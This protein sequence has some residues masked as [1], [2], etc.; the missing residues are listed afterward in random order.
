VSTAGPNQTAS[1]ST[2]IESSTAGSAA[3]SMARGHVDS[4]DNTRSR[5]GAFLK[6]LR[7][8]H[9]W[10]GLWGALL[11]LLFGITGFFLNHRA[12]PLRVPTGEPQVEMVQLKVP[13]QGFADPRALDAWVRHELGIAGRSG[14]VMREP[15]RRVAWGDRSVMQP[16]HWQLAIT[17]PTAGAQVEYWVGNDFVTVKRSSNT[18]LATL[19]NLHK[20]VGLGVPWVLLVDTLAGSLILLSITGVLLWTGMNK[21]RTTG[22]VIIGVAIVAAI[23][24]GLG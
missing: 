17:T 8:I 24:C 2:G 9:S 15:A 14:R 5:R 13:A 1:A 11:G 4:R 18:F 12:P 7:R 23:A 19:T 16:E 21:R 6:W 20:G 3:T 22:A 10:V